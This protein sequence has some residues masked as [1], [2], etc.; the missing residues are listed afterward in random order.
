MKPMTPER[1]SVVVAARGPARRQPG[2]TLIELLTVISIIGILAGMMFPVFTNVMENG[3]RASCLNNIKQLSNAFVMYS[4]E[5]GNMLPN[6]TY[7]GS[8]AAME[9]GWI[10]YSRYPANDTSAGPKAFSP[11]LGG[12]FPYIKG[13]GAYICP[14]DP[15]GKTS[16][17]SYSI[18]SNL[19]QA[20]GPGF[21]TSRMLSS[22]FWTSRWL[23]LCEEASIPSGA[24]NSSGAALQRYGT[25]DGCLLVGTDT[26][27]TRHSGGLIC[28]FLDGHAKWCRPEEI[29]AK[30]Y[31]TGG[32]GG[33]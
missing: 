11:R 10:Y 8:G 7:G 33:S 20:A 19:F 14:S 2:F 3:R 15:Q 12:L 18:N 29:T 16:G 28:A 26:F 9:G 1:S 6:C 23:L 17:N 27:S 31:L 25:D 5:S 13:P 30:Y 4:N 22:F 24:D 32:V 21:A